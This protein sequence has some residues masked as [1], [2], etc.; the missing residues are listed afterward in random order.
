MESNLKRAEPKEGRCPECLA[1]EAELETLKARPLAEHP[2]IVKTLGLVRKTKQFNGF[3]LS[4][5]TDGEGQDTWWF[6][7]IW[8]F[9]PDKGIMGKTPELA[10][11]KLALEKEMTPETLEDFVAEYPHEVRPGIKPDE[12]GVSLLVFARAVD[13]CARKEE[14]AKVLEEVRVLLTKG[15]T[16]TRPDTV[17]ENALHA[18]QESHLAI[19]DQLIAEAKG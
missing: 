9:N 13:A 17:F 4:F 11:E 12:K 3:S 16:L 14:R 18:C 6:A 10:L 19:I 5:R 1:L 15:F 8:D 7:E 2:S